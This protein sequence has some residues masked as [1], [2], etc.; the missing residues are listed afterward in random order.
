MD[1]YDDYILDNDHY[2]YPDYYGDDGDA[3]Y[4]YGWVNE[5]PLDRE[6]F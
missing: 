6:D 2:E 3:D 5:D 4:D 1:E